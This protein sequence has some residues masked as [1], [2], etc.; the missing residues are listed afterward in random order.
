V[1]RRFFELK[2]P[3]YQP[4]TESEYSNFKTLLDTAEG[5]AATAETLL[6]TEREAHQTAMDSLKESHRKE[7]ELQ[8]VQN[9]L[10]V[11]KVKLKH[12]Q[13]KD[14]RKVQD[15][16]LVAETKLDSAQREARRERRERMLLFGTLRPRRQRQQRP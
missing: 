1:N 15:K 10:L 4:P 2:A 16:L 11:T 7:L 12:S 13:G 6:K 9:E 14:L 5:R 8:K 3:S